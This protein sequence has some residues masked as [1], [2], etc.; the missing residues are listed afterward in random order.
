MVVDLLY[1]AWVRE[2]IGRD[3]E[4]LELP[5]ELATV[6]DLIGWLRARGGGY[7]EALQSPERLRAAIDQRFVPLDAPI[8]GAREIALFPP[9]TGG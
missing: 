2:A 5:A 4:R 1:F 9:V 8:V 7:A 3:G 6:A